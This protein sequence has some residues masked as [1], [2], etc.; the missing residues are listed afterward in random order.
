MFRL[1]TKAQYGLRFMLD[2]AFRNG[3]GPIPLKD[4]AK[5]EQISE[6][7]LGNL[8]LP[9][10]TARLV[11]SVRGSQGGY[12]IAKPI[13]EI[14]LCDVL[15]ALEGPLSLVECVDNPAICK[16]AGICISRSIWSEITQNFRQSLEMVTLQDM[17]QRRKGAEPV[18]K[19][20]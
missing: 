11:R 15:Q 19:A 16:A 1:T 7:Y 13:G 18:G 12:A 5:R 10:K 4:I 20:N 8:V 6:K 3:Q 9:L 2:L 14:T 17:I